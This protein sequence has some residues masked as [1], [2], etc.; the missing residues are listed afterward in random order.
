MKGRINYDYELTHTK[1]YEGIDDEVSVQELLDYAK[2]IN[3]NVGDLTIEER[4][5]IMNELKL[6]KQ[7]KQIKTVVD[8]CHVT[9]DGKPRSIAAPKE[10]GGLWSTTD[11]RDSSRRIRAKDLDTLYRKL[12]EIY[13]PE[14]NVRSYTVEKWYDIGVMHRKN[15]TNPQ[16]ST[17]LRHERTKKTYFTPQLLKSDVRKITSS[18]LWTFMREAQEKYN[19][20]LSEV[21]QLKGTLNL[22]FSAAADPE[23]GCRPSNP[24]LNVNPSGLFKNNSNAIRGKINKTKPAFSDEQIE[25]LRKRFRERIEANKLVRYDRCKYA[26]M[27]LLA[28]YTG[29][30]ASELPALKW[31]DVHDNYIHVHQM[32]IRHDGEHGDGRFEIVPWVKEEKG[33]PQG[34]RKIP[35]L[36]PNIQIIFDEIKTVQKNF[37]IE[38]DWVFPDTNSLSY[39]RSMY[40]VCK[41]MGYNITNNHAF[42]KG[43]NMWMVSKG[44][45]V[46]DRAAI[47]GHSTAVNLEKYTV[48]SDNWVEN[49]IK[50]ARSA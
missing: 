3:V 7:K 23:I 15:L 36:D 13:L 44:I 22:V 1:E 30:R 21:K 17:M 28:S 49:A 12:Y 47:L 5:H 27:G 25:A 10:E 24:L 14:A 16:K 2:M 40:M 41:R 31:E 42:R 29:M 4:D 18:E 45:N 38:S 35:F 32:Q 48:I 6:N 39:E 50:Q 37:G 9:K 43:F 33:F 34:G 8:K 11:P 20:S 26:L 46:A 19:M